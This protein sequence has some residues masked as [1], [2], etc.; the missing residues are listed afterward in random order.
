MK[1]ILLGAVFSIFML[2]VPA[3]EAKSVPNLE[4]KDRSGERHALKELRGSI[5]VVNFW[6]TFCG[7]CREELPLLYRLSQEY[8]VKH[9]RFITASAD[10]AGKPQIID[11]FFAEHQLAPPET[12][13]VW[14]GADLEM[15]ERAGLGNVLPA[16]MILDEN[17]EVLS[18]IEGEAREQDL[19]QALDWL[20]N[21]RQGPPPAPLIKRY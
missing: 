9:V 3:I 1:S 18:R 13:Q 21:G 5:T 14:T 6:A 4:F 19:R 16:T 10:D 15:L 8:G 11:K 17:G 7:P 2:S 12:I 20:L